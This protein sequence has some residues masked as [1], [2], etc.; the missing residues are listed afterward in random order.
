MTPEGREDWKKN[1]MKEMWRSAK[2]KMNKDNPD[3]EE[4]S[5]AW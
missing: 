5:N 3:T 1:D 2:D 4:P